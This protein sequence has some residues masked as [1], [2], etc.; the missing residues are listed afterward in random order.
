M[1]FDLISQETAE[2]K[3]KERRTDI[4]GR[5]VR[6]ATSVEQELSTIGVQPVETSFGRRSA[7]NEKGVHGDCDSPSRISEVILVQNIATLE[8]DITTL[9]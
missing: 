1:V 8:Y 4:F 3:E 6:E 9:L 2:D 5:P 7:A